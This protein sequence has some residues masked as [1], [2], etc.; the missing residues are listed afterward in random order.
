MS[1]TRQ[2]QIA[3]RDRYLELIEADDKRASA[4]RAAKA[5]G[6]CRETAEKW[7]R[8]EGVVRTRGEA[9]RDAWEEKYQ[10]D[11]ERYAW[12]LKRGFTVTEV[13][14]RFGTS[15]QTVYTAAQRH[16]LDLSRGSRLH[17]R[18]WDP[19]TPTGKRRR[20]MVKEM[21]RKRRKGNTL[22]EIAEGFDFCYHHVSRLLDSPLNPF[23]DVEYDPTEEYS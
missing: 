3:V 9:S 21:A 16:D 6:C 22:K 1:Y 8:K 20:E 18:S 13:A 5:V 14:E 4:G 11:W 10:D 23:T 12:Y 19:T 7:L 17:R 15:R 2:D